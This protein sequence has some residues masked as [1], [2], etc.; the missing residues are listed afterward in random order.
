MATFTNPEFTKINDLSDEDIMENMVNPVLDGDHDN[1][2]EGGSP[3]PGKQE[4][5]KPVAKPDSGKEAAKPDEAP[6]FY[7]DETGKWH[8]PDGEYASAEEAKDAEAALAP[9]G[10]PA[11]EGKE[12]AAAPETPAIHDYQPVKTALTEFAIK[13]ADGTPVTEMPELK[14]SFKAAGKDLTDVPLDK[15]VK[16]AQM[17]V[18]NEQQQQDFTQFR[19]EKEQAIQYIRGLEQTNEQ[20]KAFYESVL[21]DDNFRAQAQQQYLRDN[22]PEMQMQRQRQQIEQERQNMA[23]QQQYSQAEQYVV[24]R[25]APTVEGV[26]KANPLVTAEEV[27]GKFSM[28]TS[29]LLVN[30]IIPPDRLYDVMALAEN[31]LRPWAEQLQS[32]RESQAQ[33]TT[34]KAR[35]QV[36][37]AQVQA[38]KHKRALAAITSPTTSQGGIPAARAASQ[39]GAT[40][41]GGFKSVD[42]W[43]EQDVGI[44]P[45]S[46]R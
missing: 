44:K 32:E 46:K 43:M 36:T 34:A 22:S 8:R 27:L 39:D 31:A 42:E 40:P 21:V 11:A 25:I 19:Q 37:A 23:A 20:W 28:L 4:A 5:P 10:T 26:Q 18:Y 17:G 30:G 45:W 33:A 9:E 13:I 6:A 12:G 29:G 41:E 1:A 15:V 2:T 35:R 16:L 3:V 14:L 38:M 7:Q 24:G